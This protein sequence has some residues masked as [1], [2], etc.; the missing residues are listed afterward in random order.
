MR[1]S[2]IKRNADV[3]LLF[4][5]GYCLLLNPFINLACASVAKDLCITREFSD[6]ASLSTSGFIF[7]FD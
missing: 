4:F 7:I 3:T 2:G 6:D 5:F 1:S